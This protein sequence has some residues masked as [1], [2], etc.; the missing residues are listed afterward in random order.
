[1]RYEVASLKEASEKVFQHATADSYLNVI[2]TSTDIV[3]DLK[4]ILVSLE[5][6]EELTISIGP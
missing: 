3:R 4:R 2:H 1:M 6:M 5:I